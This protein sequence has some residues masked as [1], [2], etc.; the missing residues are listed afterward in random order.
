MKNNKTALMI[1]ILVLT[2]FP[3]FFLF[4]SLFTGQ[5]SY[6][7]W[8]IPPSFLAGFT[9]LMVTLNQIKKGTQ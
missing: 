9:G 5:W 1:S 6:L 4:V 8:S 3:V 7:A 2:G